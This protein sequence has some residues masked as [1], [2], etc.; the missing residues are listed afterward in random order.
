MFSTITGVIGSI[1]VIL[2]ILPFVIQTVKQLEEMFPEEGQGKIKFELIN[3]SLKSAYD[4]SNDLLPIVE[5]TI[6]SV[7]SVLNEFGVFSSS[8]ANKK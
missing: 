1:R 6:N 4:V 2:E 7:V 8:H 3:R 5:T